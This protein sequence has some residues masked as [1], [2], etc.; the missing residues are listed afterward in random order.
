MITEEAVSDI[1]QQGGGNAKAKAMPKSPAQATPVATCA[2]S[3]AKV[4]PL[5]SIQRIHV[6]R[7]WQKSTLRWLAA[8]YAKEL[9]MKILAITVKDLQ[10]RWKTA[11][12]SFA[13]SAR[14]YLRQ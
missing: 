4:R 6:C 8:V 3:Y 2:V 1:M 11:L 13:G 9:F 12:G 10:K 7:N 5:P 14:L